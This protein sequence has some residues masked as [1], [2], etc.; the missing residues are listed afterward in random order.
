MSLFWGVSAGAEAR[1]HCGGFV[2]GQ[3]GWASLPAFV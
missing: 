3:V 1:S 2:S